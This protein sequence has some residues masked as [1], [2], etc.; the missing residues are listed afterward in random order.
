M[1]RR[2]FIFEDDENRI[3]QF[4]EYLSKDTLTITDNI[5]VAKKLLKEQV[6]DVALLDHDMDHQSMVDS[7]EE[8]TGFQ[9][10]SFI[11]EE[12]IPLYQ[13]IVHS[14][15][16]VGAE[17]M[18]DVLNKFGEHIKQVQMLPFFYLSREL[19]ILHERSL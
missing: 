5:H 12:K 11:V 9:V 18:I 13:V 7:S 15:N 2:I 17:R 10:A 1:G 19:K 16:P 3:E 4:R 8:N 6:F 14:H